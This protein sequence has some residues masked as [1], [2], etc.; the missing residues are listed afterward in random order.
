MTRTSSRSGTRPIISR[1]ARRTIG[2][3]VSSSLSVGRTRLIVRSCFSLSVHEPAQVGELGVVEVRL[4]EPALDAGRDRARLLGRPVGGGQRLGPR[5]QLLERRALDRLAG[6]DDDDR[7]AGAGRDRLGQRPEQVRLAV[8]SARLRG[9][10]HDDEVGLLR[11][12]QDRVAD[13]GRLAQD[14]L[15]ATADVLLDEGGQGALGLGADRQRDPGRDEVED[16]D[17]RLVTAGDG[18]GE[19]QRELGVRAAADRDEDPPDLP[20]AALLDD[21]DVAGR[22]AHDLVDRRGEDHRSGAVA[23]PAG[24]AAPAEDDEVGLLLGGRLDDALGGMAPD[25]HDRVD[26]RPV[27][28][29]VEDALEEPAGVAGPGRALGQRHPLGHL[30]DPERGQLTGPLVEHGGAEPDELL[31]RHRV[32]DRDQDPGGRGRSRVVGRLARRTAPRRPRSSAAARRR[33]QRS[34]RYGLSSSNSRAC[35]S[36]RSS[37]CS[38]VR[39][40][41]SMTKLADP[42][43]V[44]RDERGD[45]RLERRHAGRGRPR[46]GR[47]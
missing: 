47:R 43:E 17:G 28:G 35:R 4:A 38:V 19:A 18:V 42:A 10:A 9:G 32:G 2:P 45:Q 16:D 22:V 30:D 12:A 33:P 14:R 41:F 1:I 26:R 23:R 25:P 13:V 3:I 36:T 20:G 34:T 6:L 5:G 8:S 24:A 15:A 44:D 27:G 40:R 11:L 46:P 39:C 7:R 29:E 37:A 21:G 31:G